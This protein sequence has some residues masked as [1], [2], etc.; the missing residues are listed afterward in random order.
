M[1]TYEKR[2]A[3]SNH[4]AESDARVASSPARASGDGFA[5]DIARA[6]RALET[7]DAAARRS[8]LD[9]LEALAR[10]AEEGRAPF[11]VD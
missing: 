1:S 10:G 2:L 8:A 3:M 5:E 9:L 6:V 11:F 4:A 7:M